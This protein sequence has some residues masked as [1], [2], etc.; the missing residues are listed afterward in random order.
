MQKLHKDYAQLLRTCSTRY[1]EKISFTWTVADVLQ[2]L[3][4]IIVVILLLIIY[5]APAIIAYK[6][7]HAYKHVILGVNAIGFVGVLPWVAAFAW[8]AWP[9][10]KSLIDPLAGNV[11]GKGKRNTG[12]TIGSMQYGLERGYE[13]EK[14]S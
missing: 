8:A 6:R 14:N 11:T 13:E 10:N 12:D 9:S 2:G 1:T 4:A 5:F 7:N 3:F